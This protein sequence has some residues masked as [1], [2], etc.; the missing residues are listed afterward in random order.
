MC[1]LVMKDE[2]PLRWNNLGATDRVW[3]DITK[4]CEA[5]DDSLK[6]SHLK[7][8]CRNEYLSDICHHATQTTTE[9]DLQI[10]ALV[11]LQV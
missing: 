1:W 4:V 3:K 5:F 6:K 10:K 9:L 2:G 11:S 8:Q 7:W